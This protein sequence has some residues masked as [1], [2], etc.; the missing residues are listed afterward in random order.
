[1]KND[2]F[3]LITYLIYIIF[4]EGLLFGGCGYVVF[5]LNYSGWWFVLAFVLST[6]AYTP[7]KWRKL[8]TNKFTK[9]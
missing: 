2:K 3:I 1:M 9:P 8:L 6:C 4:W 7:K 5:I